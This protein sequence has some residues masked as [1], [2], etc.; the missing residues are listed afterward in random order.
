MLRPTDCILQHFLFN[1]HCND[2]CKYFE[3]ENNETQ[4]RE[5]IYLYTY[6]RMSVYL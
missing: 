1:S 2:R 4:R 5:Y 3:T 6:S